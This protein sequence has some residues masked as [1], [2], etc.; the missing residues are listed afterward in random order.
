MRY[1][2]DKAKRGCQGHRGMRHPQLESRDL[3]QL[4]WQAASG[5]GAMPAASRPQA[6][7]RSRDPQP[8][9][10]RRNAPVSQQLA[11]TTRQ[12]H[13]VQEM[14]RFPPTERSLHP[15]PGTDG[16]GELAASS[17]SHAGCSRDGSFIYFPLPRS[18]CCSLCARILVRKASPR[19]LP[20]LAARGQA[21]LAATSC[22]AVSALA[23]CGR[24]VCRASC[25]PP[26]SR[27]V[28]LIPPGITAAKAALVAGGQLAAG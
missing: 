13:V 22:T 27:G 9:P 20:A 6:Q 12:D 25:S 24:F 3:Q 21:G 2:Q 28:P 5:A 18:C 15:Q 14:R 11:H 10:G 16:P 26:R 23:C 7:V 19:L 1:C 8:Q 17:A 4:R